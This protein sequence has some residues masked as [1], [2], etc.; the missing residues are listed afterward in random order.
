MSGWSLEGGA[1]PAY[2]CQS[3]LQRVMVSAV[4]GLS[5]RVRS[6]GCRTHVCSQ[7]GTGPEVQVDCTWPGSAASEGRA[8]SWEGTGWQQEHL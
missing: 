6:P 1:G 4:L 5:S 2:L 8:W 7:A 3:G